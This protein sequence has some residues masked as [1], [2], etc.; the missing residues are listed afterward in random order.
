[1]LLKD[2]IGMRLELGKES[3][4]PLAG[5]QG[6]STGNGGPSE[7]AG[8]A[9]AGEI[10]VHR[11]QMHPEG[12]GHVGGEQAAVSGLHD[13]EAE[14]GGIGVHPVV[15]PI[16]LPLEKGSRGQ[17]RVMGNNEEKATCVN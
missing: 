10:A 6:R 3:G 9:A 11:G 8:L 12:A 17:V 14:V 15:Y 2:G 16:R 7:A 1:M 13:L 5:D 4:I